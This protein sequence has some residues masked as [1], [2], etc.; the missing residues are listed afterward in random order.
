MLARRPLRNLSLLLGGSVAGLIAANAAFLQDKSHPAP[1]FSTRAAEEVAEPPPPV[2]IPPP[3]QPRLV[4]TV[5]VEGPPSPPAPAAPGPVLE[6]RL[7][8]EIQSG[9]AALG[10]Y[11]G[12]IDGVHGPHTRAAVAAYQERAGLAVSGEPSEALALRLAAETLTRGAAP[13]GPATPAIDQRLL[14]VERAL[15]DIGYGPVRV[16]GLSSGDTADAIRRFQ[17]DHGLRI[18]G[19][20]DDAVVRK[21]MQIGALAAI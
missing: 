4:K 7:V 15:N 12:E 5:A 1:F 17:L 11:A 2:P 10:F 9:L 16:D 21:L 13:A 19:T 20:A 3:R 8:Q 18:T 14:E 6:R